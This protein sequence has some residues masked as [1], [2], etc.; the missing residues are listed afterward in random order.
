MDKIFN[1]RK[2]ISLAVNINIISYYIAYN[3]IITR[4]RVFFVSLLVCY[5]GFSVPAII[6]KIKCK[7]K[8]LSISGG[9]FRRYYGK[10]RACHDSFE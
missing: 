7:A 3:F 8:A 1:Q 4:Q 6:K 9:A 5:I 2:I 10:K